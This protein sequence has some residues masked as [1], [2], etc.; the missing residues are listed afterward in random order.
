MPVELMYAT[1]EKSSTI[2]CAEPACEYA[3]SQRRL[4][5]AVDVSRELDH[6]RSRLVVHMRVQLSGRHRRHLLSG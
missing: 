3:S 4:G 5:V 1:P 2:D 6:G